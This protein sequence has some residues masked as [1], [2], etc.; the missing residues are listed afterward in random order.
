MSS[1][2]IEQVMPSEAK[3]VVESSDNKNMY[4]NGIFMMGGIK[5]RNGRVYQPQEISRAVDQLN[6]Q[7]RSGFSVMGELNHPDNLSINLDRVSHIITEMRMVGN[8]AIGKAKVL[9]TPCGNIVKALINGG[10]K[11]GVSSRGSGNVTME[12]T[13]NDFSFITVDVVANPSAPNA[14]PDVIRE[15]VENSK[16][17][18]LAEAAVHD[19]KAQAYLKQEMMKFLDSIFK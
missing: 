5:N 11:L 18:S 13:V 10:A 8:N 7:V 9:D 16:I 19:E 1:L 12:G 6:E 3:L 2:L 17:M 4:L 15:S 14:Y